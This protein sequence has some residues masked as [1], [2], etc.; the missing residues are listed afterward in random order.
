MCIKV[1]A[2]G[3]NKHVYFMPTNRNKVDAFCCINKRRNR[4]FF[5]NEYVTG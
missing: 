1:Y 3:Q 2:V 5:S 4:K